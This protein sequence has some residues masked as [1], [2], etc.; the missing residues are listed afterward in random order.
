MDPKLPIK[1]LGY[2]ELYLSNQSENVKH[3]LYLVTS[4]TSGKNTFGIVQLIQWL[5]DHRLS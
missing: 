4:T 3:F 1:E 5:Q 2:L